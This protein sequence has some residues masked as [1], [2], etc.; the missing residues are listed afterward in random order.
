MGLLFELWLV[1]CHGFEPKP[2]GWSKA[3]FRH[4][5]AGPWG[6]TVLA[7]KFAAR[8]A[9]PLGSRHHNQNGTGCLQCFWQAGPNANRADIPCSLMAN[10]KEAICSNLL[11]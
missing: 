5:H 1:N 6:E 2:M 7:P 4:S 3:E 8:L 11:W 9:M 10:L